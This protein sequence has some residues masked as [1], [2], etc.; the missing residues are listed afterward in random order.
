MADFF[1]GTL[2]NTPVNYDSFSVTPHDPKDV[3]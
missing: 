2:T 1:L 3:F